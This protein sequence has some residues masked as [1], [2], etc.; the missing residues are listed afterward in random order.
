VAKKVK[1]GDVFLIPIEGD[2]YG[3]GQIAGNWKGELYIVIYDRVVSADAS[4]KLIDGASLQFAA[5][6]LDAKIHHGDWPIIGNRQDNIETIPQPWFKVGYN[7]QTYVEA[8]DRSVLRVATAKEEAQLRLRTVVAPV[9]L[10][11]ALKAR[12]GIGVWHPT[13]NDL[14]A[15]YASESAALVGHE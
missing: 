12:N 7:G 5:L 1:V 2:R 9:R 6:S 11:K 13:Y 14:T 3:I 15:E 10:E 8:R 4:L